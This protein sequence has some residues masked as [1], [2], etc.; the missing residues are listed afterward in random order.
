[1]EKTA[2]KKTRIIGLFKLAMINVAAIISITNL[3][4]M[5]V[6]GL[7][8]IAYFILA[9]IF[10]FLPMS[11]VAAELATGWPLR[12][13]F[14]SWVK[15]GMGPYWGFLAIWLQWAA[16]IVW[17]PT[18]MVPAVASIAY[19]IKPEMANN[20]WFMF[21]GVNL[22]YWV[23]TVLNLRGMKESS[24][25]SAIGVITG[26]LIPG[27]VM[28]AFAV[29]WLATG[30]SSAVTFHAKDLVPPIGNLNSLVLLMGLITTL[31]GMEMSAVHVNDVKNP[32]H[33]YPR[34]IFLCVGIVMVISILAS[35]GLAIL[36][37]STQ[38]NIVAG[39]MQGYELFSHTFN[40][41]WMSVILGILLSIG[42]LTMASTWIGGPA[43]GVQVA[44][45][46][47]DVP[48]FFRKMN[49]KEMPV[50]VMMIEGI[51]FS[52]L[53]VSFL[54]LPSVSDSFWALI[55]L[56]SEMY[57]IM[58]AILFITGIVMRYRYPKVYR[59]YRIPGRKNIGMWLVAGAG[60]IGTISSFLLTL[61]PPS[62]IN[63]SATKDYVFLLLG[64]FVLVT[65]VPFAIFA[66][67]QYRRRHDHSHRELVL[68]RHAS[69]VPVKEI[70]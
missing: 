41:P 18:I 20:A 1:M 6:T 67:V 45:S 48:A 51:L 46:D 56:T 70:E 34:A 31:S 29:I 61:V 7:T 42:T 50:R 57:M 59:S 23:I 44:A 3:P 65:F 49:R 53:S 39:M 58:Y 9:A 27:I 64:A 25:L 62:G 4:I 43:K 17:Y 40:M 5:S 24:T 55:A 66:V 21:I 28:V 36:I 38:I 12:G 14:Y 35:L 63:V 11:F 22:I 19:L 68:M 15:L 37:P 69:H 30:H 54:V 8:L 16:N 52:C 33:D 13:G 10:F 26:S 2:E 47:G 32:Q 60:I